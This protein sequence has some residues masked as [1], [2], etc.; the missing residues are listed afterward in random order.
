MYTGYRIDENWIWGPYNSGK[1]Y[2]GGQIFNLD[3]SHC[4]NFEAPAFVKIK[5][6]TP[7]S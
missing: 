6:L 7:D 2:I 4:Q 3:K 5:D 1:L